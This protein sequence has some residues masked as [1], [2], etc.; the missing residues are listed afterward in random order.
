M[1][2]GLGSFLNLHTY[3]HSKGTHKFQIF[4]LISNPDR[5]FESH[6]STSAAPKQ[7]L[8]PHYPA[9]DISFPP[10]NNRQQDGLL[11]HRHPGALLR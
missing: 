8:P 10:S 1:N 4:F 9:R 11:Q 3:I 7:S 2:P 6:E 5:A